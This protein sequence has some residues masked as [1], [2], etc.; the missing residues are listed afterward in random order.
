MK[1][2]NRGEFVLG[3]IF[4]GAIFGTVATIFFRDVLHRL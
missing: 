4:I 2:N 3:F 1:L